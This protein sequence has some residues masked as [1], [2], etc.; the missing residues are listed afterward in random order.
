MGEVI[1]PVKSLKWTVC[2]GV[3]LAP[4]LLAVPAS[5]ADEV[6]SVTSIIS[7]PG[8][9]V[10]GSFDIEF[11]DPIAGVFLL[12]DRTNKSID[13]AS[14]STNLI[15]SQLQPGFAGVV[16]SGSTACPTAG[17]TSPL[18]P[19]CSG[20]NG[21]LAIHQYG[22]GDPQGNGKGKG[23]A[24]TEVWVGDGSSQVW[25]L[26]LTTGSPVVPP[27]ST[28]LQGAGTD[29]TRA[30]EL[31]Y[32]P[33][34]SIIMIANPN[35]NPIGFV[36]FISTRNYKVL[37]YIVM[38]G[39]NGTGFNTHGGETPPYAGGGI[40]QCQYSPRTKKFYLNVPKASTTPGGTPVAD[41]VLQIDP[42]SEAILNT[43]N[44]TTQ[45]LVSAPSTGCVTKTQTAAGTTGM[46]L[47]P[48]SQIA[49]A[50]GATALGSVVISE[51]F[52]SDKTPQVYGLA[53]ETGADEIWYNPG[54][55]HYFYATR[56]NV[57]ASFVGSIATCTPTPCTSATL[58]VTLVNSGALKVGDT[59]TGVGV[60]PGTTITGNNTM[61]NSTGCNPVPKTCLGMGATGTY[62]L[63]TPQTVASETMQEA[64][65][66]PSGLP[67][68]LILG[69]VDACGEPSPPCVPQSDLP[70]ATPP[71]VSISS[72]AAAD[73]AANQ[74]YAAVNPTGAAA[75]NICA[76][77][78]D[79]K[80][81]PGINANGCIAIFT[82]TSGT[83]DPGS[84]QGNQNGQGKQ[85]GQ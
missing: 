4:W 34:D 2:L 3:A 59:L 16:T 55:N 40:E 75:S 42:K 57:D 9:Q 41:L 83:D 21:V 68:G 43:V 53:G 33:D 81:N 30:D 72:K 11:V 8:S 39:T 10:L 71:V 70:V 80:G 37:G 74:L 20:P 79:A 31:C 45:S 73:P 69:V 22:Q 23:Q 24:K 76:A 14:T 78:K 46:A 36:T 56:M 28:A 60:A 85:N 29:P 66:L 64:K 47:G 49:I 32:D 84:S 52:S 54:D 65:F 35:S 61:G 51:E 12:A 82:V 1:M 27:I 6:F 50:C 15:T 58:T 26:N 13:V 44:L 63:S 18:A 77:N 25:A 62:A 7:L 5:A 48:D 17:R 67:A 19:N 38:D